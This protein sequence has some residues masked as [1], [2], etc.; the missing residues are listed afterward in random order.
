[1]RVHKKIELS[2]WL[3]VRVH[4][5]VK[6]SD[7]SVVRAHKNGGLSNLLFVTANK[8]GWVSDWFSSQK[9]NNL[10]GRLLRS[11]RKDKTNR[12]AISWG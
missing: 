9:E 7:W 6:L 11:Q 10:I 3:L 5:K 4:K 1:M 12:A 2:D 8:D